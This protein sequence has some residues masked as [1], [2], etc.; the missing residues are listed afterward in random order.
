MP[1]LYWPA[2]L[3][4]WKALLTNRFPFRAK[5][6]L[7]LFLLKDLLKQPLW[8]FLW[9]LDAVLFPA[10][11]RMKVE[12]PIFIVSQPRSGTT[13]LHR[14]LCD[15]EE[16]FFGVTYLEWHWP[17]VS[18][19]WLIDALGLRSWIESW[20]YW[21]EGCLASKM[22]P[23]K[24]GD[25]EEHGVFLEEQFYCHY[26]VYRRFPFPE[27]IAVADLL[28][29]TTEKQRTKMARSLLSVVSKVQVYRA[30]GKRWVAKENETMAF[31]DDLAAQC[32]RPSWILLERN[33]DDM[34]KSYDQLSL[35]STAAK[36]GVWMENWNYGQWWS[37]NRAF[38]STEIHRYAFIKDAVTDGL[39]VRYEW[40]V[41]DISETVLNLLVGLG[42]APTGAYLVY[43]EE[44]DEKQKTRKRGY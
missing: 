41:A 21:P 30:A 9:G 19:W 20:D 5:A 16:R 31:Y 37:L 27:V 24:F 36:T 7:A 2:Y 29:F 28:I 40:M 11:K 10:Y 43:L 18:V 8:A 13:F 15:F 33:Y 22:H 4:I 23:H 25:F 32:D 12:R 3:L 35:Y 6:R 44:L 14:T 26:F 39:P 34:I 42:E 17:F 38:R 1:L